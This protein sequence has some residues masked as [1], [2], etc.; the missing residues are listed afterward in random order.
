LGLFMPV[1][2]PC[3]KTNVSL[4]VSNSSVLSFWN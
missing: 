1:R 2:L 3:G 4:D